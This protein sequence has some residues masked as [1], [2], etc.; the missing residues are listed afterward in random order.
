MK[1]YQQQ[2]KKLTIND[3]Q[4]SLQM[5]GV[6]DIYAKMQ[7]DLF[8]RMIKRLKERGS[9]DLMRNPYI[10]Q[11]EKLSDMHL[12]N[13][14]NLKL[15]S[16]RTNIAERLLR[17]VI[18][19]EGLKV[20]QDTKQQLEE[21]LGKPSSGHIKNGVT[22]SLEAYTRQAVSDLNLINTTLPESLQAVYKSVVEET[23]AQVVSG[24]KT[25]DQ[26]LHDT[27]MSWQKRGFTGFVDKGGREWR[28]DAYA[29]AIIKT[30]TYRVYN[31]MRITPAEE[32]GI[33]TFYYSMKATARPACSP[34][35]GQIVTKGQAR[36]ENGITVYS[37]LDYGYGTAGGCLG[38]HCGH[39]LTPFVIG[40]NELP[41]L[42]SYLK[43]LTPEQAEDNA[44][45]EAK[46]RSLERIIKNHK[47]RLHYAKTMQDDKMIEVE[48]LKVRAYQVKINT[49][50]L[51]HDF[52][53]RD[54]RRE[55]LY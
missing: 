9:I 2:S 43:D 27:I 35:Q 25:S 48:R 5:Q 24:T 44:R 31:E 4:F 30:T 8:D 42:P 16:E 12:L 21:D 45:I 28:A 55:K 50:V 33:D 46:Q 6:T 41:N 18:E 54:Y 37:L 39:Y 10:W 36:E 40:V 49:L 29:R 14:A 51:Q 3:Q 38:I 23:V 15:I 53:H 13:D 19:N 47:E 26:A 52:L 20:Y 1:N 22:D 17:D 7:I 11:L 34:L 32:L